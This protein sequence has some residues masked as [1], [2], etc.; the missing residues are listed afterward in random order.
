VAETAL[1]LSYGPLLSTTLFNYRRTLMDNIS[2]S[3]VIFYKIKQSDAYKV[4]TDG[5]GERCQIPLMY[6]LGS[7]DVYHGYDE[8][9]MVPTEG[10]TSAFFDWAQFAAPIMISRREERMN[11]G[12]ARILSLLESKVKQAEI[13]I[14]EKFAKAFIQ[15]NGINVASQITTPY[16]STANGRIFIDP[17]PKLVDYTPAT[18]VVGSIDPAVEAWWRNQSRAFTADTTYAL[19]LRGLD[20]L[21]NNCSKGPGGPPNLFLTDQS[22]FELYVSALRSQNRFVEYN[23]ADIPFENVAFYGMPLVWDEFMIDAAGDTVTQS[24]GSGTIYMLNTRFF[25]MYA[26]GETNWTNSEFK[27]PV[28]QDAKVSFIK[29]MGSAGVSNRRKLGVGGDIDTTIAA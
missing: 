3:N 20:R 14:Q 8:L 10:I 26:D 25:H 19:F 15:G 16:T 2:T 13:T 17:L 24:A 7:A 28:N 11:S 12:E 9:D 21:R 22:V 27:E 23:K 4:I 1:S 5:L 6:G 29:W 18:G